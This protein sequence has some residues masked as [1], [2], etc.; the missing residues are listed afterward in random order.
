MTRRS[1]SPKPHSAELVLG[2]AQT[3][4]EEAFLL[5]RGVERVWM[6]GRG[7]ESLAEVMRAFRLRPGVLAVSADLRC[8]SD[9]PEVKRIDV[10]AALAWFERAK[11]T[12][13]DCR[14]PSATHAEL[15]DRAFK[16]VANARFTK[17]KRKAKREGA[18]GG[19]AKG[20]AAAARRNAEVSDAIAR[21]LCECPKLNWKDR[22]GI[23]GM[24]VASIHRH[25]S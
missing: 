11:I 9:K 4:D 10:V 23:L 1:N 2:F 7:A 22:A 12:V 20:L 16:S 18:K 15:L 13:R 21:R 25:Y 17:N 14:D 3:K 6:K 8:L 5:S 24:S 19:T